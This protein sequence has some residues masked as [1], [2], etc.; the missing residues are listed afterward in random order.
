M[1]DVARERVRTRR[2]GSLGALGVMIRAARLVA[3]R[4]REPFPPWQGM[5]HL[6]DMFGGRDRLDPLD[7]RRYPDLRW[8]PVRELLAARRRS[9]QRAGDAR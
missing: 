2:A 9:D 4:P 1:T 8:T 5:Q 3:P 7:T 6:R